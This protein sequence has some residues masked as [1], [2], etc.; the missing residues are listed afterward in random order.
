MN[1]LET[2]TA[3]SR[4]AA[5]ASLMMLCAMILPGCNSEDMVIDIPINE[6]TSI[7]LYEPKYSISINN[8]TVNNAYAYFVMDPDS[9]ESM[10]VLT[11][12]HPAQEL[13]IPISATRN[14]DGNIVFEGEEL[15]EN[16]RHIKVDGLYESQQDENIERS[17]RSLLKIDVS[18]T[19]PNEMFNKEYLIPFDGHNGFCYNR[20][21]EQYPMSDYDIEAQRDSCDLICKKINVAL[22]EYIKSMKFKFSHDG[23]LTVEIRVSSDE[24]KYFMTHLHIS[25][26]WIRYDN[27]FPIVS[28]ENPR[29]FYSSLLHA[30][31]LNVNAITLAECYMPDYFRLGELYLGVDDILSDKR[32]KTA[33]VLRDIFQYN[34]FSLMKGR[35]NSG[36]KWTAE[37]MR[38][39][40]SMQNICKKSY[41]E[42]DTPMS[43]YEWAFATW[44]E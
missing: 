10:V 25:R 3:L 5:I 35:E 42:R 9:G 27:G 30:C 44:N 23:I 34:V 7:K 21:L 13:Q 33:V 17:Q 4:I 36:E 12:L 24:N 22:G 20:N 11:G 26:F 8:E 41:S 14:S 39:F 2:N 40:D 32:F 43:R 16:V 31:L 37:D 15:V 1:P 38:F 6:L 19:V 18:Y 29:L 28:F